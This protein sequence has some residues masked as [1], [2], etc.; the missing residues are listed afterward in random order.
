MPRRVSDMPK[1]SRKY[2]SV[3]SVMLILAVLISFVPALKEHIT[4]FKS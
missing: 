1:L 3:L 2:C 4:W